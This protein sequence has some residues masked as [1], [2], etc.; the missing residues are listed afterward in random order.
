MRPPVRSAVAYKPVARSYLDKI[1]D[2]VAI[3]ECRLGVRIWCSI[4]Y[5]STHVA[6]SILA[7]RQSLTDALHFKLLVTTPSNFSLGRLCRS[8]SL[9]LFF[10]I[11]SSV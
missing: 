8:P 6:L 7:L 1:D 2:A 9:T 3:D 4:L 10:Y 5:R 11:V